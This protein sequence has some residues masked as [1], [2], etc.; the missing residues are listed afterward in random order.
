MAR[1]ILGSENILCE[2]VNVLEEGASRGTR[3]RV[4]Y[5][6]CSRSV[7]DGT[8]N[9]SRAFDESAAIFFVLRDSL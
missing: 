8:C 1:V 6:H 7:D 5:C 2:L 9:R 3:A 4:R